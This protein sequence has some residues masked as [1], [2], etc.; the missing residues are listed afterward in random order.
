MKPLLENFTQRTTDPKEN[1]FNEIE[2]R[3]SNKNGN[4][5]TTMY[6]KLIKHLHQHNGI[7]SGKCVPA[8]SRWKFINGNVILMTVSYSNTLRQNIL[9][10]ERWKP[11][12]LYQKYV[13]DMAELIGYL[14]RIHSPLFVQVS[15]ANSLCYTSL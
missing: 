14:L 4:V 9:S 5:F 7:C 8:F 13:G 15:T 11:I 1:N 10:V 6:R 2:M 12:I 3:V